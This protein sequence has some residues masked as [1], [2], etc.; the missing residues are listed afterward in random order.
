MAV[1]G[2]VGRAMRAFSVSACLVW[3]AGCGGGGGDTS[4]TGNT[5]GTGGTG[6][7]TP[8]VLQKT[9]S[10][11]GWVSHA[12]PLA[13]GKVVLAVQLNGFSPTPEELVTESATIGLAVWDPNSGKLAAAA[14]L[15]LPRPE[16]DRYLGAA[17]LDRRFGYNV[18][19]I[20]ALPDGGLVLQADLFGPASVAETDEGKLH[21]IVRLDAALKLQWSHVWRTQQPGRLGLRSDGIDSGGVRY[22]YDG[23]LVSAA[24]LSAWTNTELQGGRAVYGGFG[25]GTIVRDVAGNN[26]FRAVPAV[27]Y[28]S[29]PDGQGG[30]WLAGS[31][32]NQLALARLDTQGNVIKAVRLDGT[33]PDGWRDLV[34][35]GDAVYTVG[36]RSNAAGGND[37][38]VCRFTGALVLT[39]CVVGPDGQS[40]TNTSLRVNAQGTRLYVARA[41]RSQN[42]LVVLDANLDVVAGYGATAS[43]IAANASALD[44]AVTGTVS[45]PVPDLA[46]RR[47]ALGVSVET[48]DPAAI[49]ADALGMMV[50]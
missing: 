50:R 12:E 48:V 20:R 3:I 40:F 18:T 33:T 11:L 47:L 39:R 7:T 34:T 31:A 29:A 44:L 45:V 37:W 27:I 4:A 41:I 36:P 49:D 22:R 17:S 1:N 28:A 38:M 2:K 9:H 8:P 21:L 23:T 46:S 19:D 16:L 10:V 43:S 15:S 5:G 13:D 35:A 14:R 24:S 26:E 42:P 25:G 32:G 6:G 30:A